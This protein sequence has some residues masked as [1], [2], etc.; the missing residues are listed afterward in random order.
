MKNSAAVRTDR[1][2]ECK[3]RMVQIRFTLCPFV[4]GRSYP[5]GVSLGVNRRGGDEKSPTKRE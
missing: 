1:Q 3:S 2:L 5:M 4:K